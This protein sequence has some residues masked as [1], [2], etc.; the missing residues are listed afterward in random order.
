[1]ST[2][3]HPFTRCS[4]SLNILFDPIILFY[5]NI[6]YH[7]REMITLGHAMRFA[8]RCPMSDNQ[9][10]TFNPISICVCNMRCPVTDINI[11]LFNNN[12]N[13]KSSRKEVIFLIEFASFT[14]NSKFKLDN[15]TMKIESSF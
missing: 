5:D 7:Q 3:P 10:P 12:R 14:S 6:Q 8:M 13:H 15:S 1:M 11:Q 9:S 2:F 4:T